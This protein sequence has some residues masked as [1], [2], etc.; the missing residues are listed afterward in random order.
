MQKVASQPGG[1]SL[2]KPKVGAAAAAFSTGDDDDDD[3]EEEMPPEA[4]MRMKNIGRWANTPSMCA[5]SSVLKTTAPPHTKHNIGT[6][7]SNWQG[8]RMQP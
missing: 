3:E 5:S 8:L 2:L 7:T 1:A 4:K 6:H